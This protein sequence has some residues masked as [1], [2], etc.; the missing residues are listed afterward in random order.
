[1][2]TAKRDQIG[3][4]HRHETTRDCTSSTQQRSPTDVDQASSSPGVT[5]SSNRCV[6]R[7][8]ENRTGTSIRASEA[9]VD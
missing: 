9:F 1:M 4:I 7:M 6:P 5:I 3:V 8:I 2:P